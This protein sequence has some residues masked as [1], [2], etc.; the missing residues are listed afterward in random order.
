MIH[1]NDNLYHSGVKGM[2]WGVRKDKRG[3]LPS[4][5]KLR[6][7]IKN[8]N[9]NPDNNRHTIK[10]SKKF[11]K[12]VSNTK[13]YKRMMNSLEFWDALNKQAQAQGGRLALTREQMNAHNKTVSDAEKKASEVKKKYVD[14]YASAMLKDLGYKDTESGRNYLKKKGLV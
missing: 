12:E 4:A 11:A 10:V 8:A 2:K 6:K 7:Q 1:Y 13:E 9:K 5:R 3:G 14:Q